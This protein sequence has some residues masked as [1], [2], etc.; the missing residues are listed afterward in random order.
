M[1]QEGEV[2]PIAAAAER[3]MREIELATDVAV[4]SW[5]R[6]AGMTAQQW[7]NLY[8][9]RVQFAPPELGVTKLR[10]TITA[11]ARQYPEARP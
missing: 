1:A 9:P 8:E 6:Q 5:A 2:S 7:I 11:H 4:R 10:Y 3:M